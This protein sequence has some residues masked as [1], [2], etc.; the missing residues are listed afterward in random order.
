MGLKSFQIGVK[1]V[2]VVDGRV[3]LLKR[4]DRWSGMIW[5]MPG[6]RMEVGEEIAETLR[7]ELREEVPSIGRIEIGAL[8]HAARV[9]HDWGEVGL[10][11]LFYRV[12]AE[13]A[14]VVLSDE[15]VGYA[16]VGV[17]DLPA[18]ECGEDGV[19][20]FEYTLAALRLALQ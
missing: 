6:G 3:L 18:L 14:E 2:V 19:R 8:L 4:Q 17:E 11:L 7:R 12:Q 1:G 15:H 10:V 16:W 5:E 9:P 20:T 13:V